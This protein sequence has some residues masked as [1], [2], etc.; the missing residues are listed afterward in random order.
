[1]K[2]FLLFLS[3]LAILVACN[4]TPVSLEI[5]KVRPRFVVPLAEIVIT[6]AGFSNSSVVTIG[7][8]TV[9]VTSFQTTELKVKAPNLQAGAYLVT[10]TNSPQ[11]FA[12]SKDLNILATADNYFPDQ[13]LVVFKENTDINKATRLPN[14]LV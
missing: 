6:G 7:G 4:P 10:V 5:Q 13:A 2:R 14:A 11:S 12:T 3:T 9:S 1:M 8:Q